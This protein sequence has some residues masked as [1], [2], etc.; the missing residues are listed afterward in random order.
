M[1]KL[2]IPNHVGIIVDGNGRWATSRGKN[3]SYG[4][5]AG[6][7]NLKK[8][9]KHIFNSGI[10]IF[11]AYIFSTENFKRSQE[12]VNYLMDLFVTVFKR[13]FSDFKKEN[14]KIVFSGS[15]E[16]LSKKVLNAMDTIVEETKDNTKGILNLCLNYGSHKEIIDAT[17]KIN[18]DVLKGNLN[19]DDL[20]EDLYYKYLYNDLPPI[21]LLIRTSGEMRL[22]NFMLYQLSYAEL[23]FVNTYFPDFNE[24]EFDK[25][26]VEFSSRERRFGGIPT[27]NKIDN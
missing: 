16:N 18:E 3:R 1:T 19:I 20:D 2:K 17:K 5:K 12:E 9:I 23:M 22:S 7:D 25:C 6:S 8:L 11:S 26:L 10:K 4:H 15:R 24:Q 13:E 21:D 14:I 27:S